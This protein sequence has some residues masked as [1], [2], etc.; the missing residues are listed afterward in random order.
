MSVAVANAMP[1]YSHLAARHPVWPTLPLSIPPISPTLPQPDTRG[2]AAES[3]SGCAEGGNSRH[4]VVECSSYQRIRIGHAGDA[5]SGDESEALGGGRSRQHHVA[6]SEEPRVNPQALHP[7]VS[8][9]MAGGSLFSSRPV[10]TADGSLHGGDRWM[11]P[12]GGG[13]GRVF[14]C[15]DQPI[16]PPGQLF[17]NVVRRAGAASWIL[18][19]PVQLRFPTT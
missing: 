16:T 9:N 15:G 17:T 11:G 5:R 14:K 19:M 8:D 13:I 2:C 18:Q 4:V 12:V 1:R 7:L 6:G 10:M 3:T